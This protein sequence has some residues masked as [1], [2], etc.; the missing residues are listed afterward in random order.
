MESDLTI[1]RLQKC[2]KN[3][4]HKNNSNDKYMLKLMEEVGE[5]AKVVMK[6]KRME[7]GKSIK[8]TIEEELQDVLYYLVCLA[9]INNI[10]LQE[11]IYEKEKLNCEKYNRNNMFYIDMEKNM[12]ENIIFDIGGVLV[13][14]NPKTYLDKLSIEN[15]KRNELNNIIFHN[16]KWKDCLNGIITNSELIEYLVNENLNY[17]NEIEQ[18]LSKENLKY[19]LPPKKDMIKYYKILKQRGYKIY[20]CSNIIEDTYNYIKD[21]FEIIQIA[22]GGVFSCFENVSKPNNEI[23]YNLINKYKIDIKKSI[24]IDDT[25]ANIDSANRMGFKTILFKDIKQIEKIL[26]I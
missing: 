2:I 14:Y 25:K 19:M 6:N 5:L 4:N 15:T 13:D 7:K 21:N 20:L 8:G 3:I 22:D 10:D 9:N 17:K 24:F 1:R 12:I 23:Y 26:K 18:I 16:Q 11:C